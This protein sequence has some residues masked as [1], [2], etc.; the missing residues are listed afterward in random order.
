[1]KFGKIILLVVFLVLL[2]VSILMY[3]NLKKLQKTTKEQNLEVHILRNSLDELRIQ[4]NLV[5]NDYTIIYN[6]L[7]DT[8]ALNEVA[9]EE[10]KKITESHVV[11]VENLTKYENEVER[12]KEE[13]EKAQKIPKH[14]MSIK[15]KY[16]D[17]EFDMMCFVVQHECGIFGINHKRLIAQVI[18]NRVGN[19]RFGNTIKDVLLQRSQFT[20]IKHYGVEDLIIDKHTI[21]A[22]YEVLHGI[23]PDY[24]QGALFF[25]NPTYISEQ[26]RID[27]FENNYK[28]LFTVDGHRFLR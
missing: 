19:A 23:T 10:L 20:C 8:Q 14:S 21:R 24:S 18:F 4:N 6:Q 9:Q 16:T 12:L 15:V 2:T 25:Y 17:E 27:Y 26:W 13:L 11:M 3:S 1:M 7:N 22:V 5:N 28:Y